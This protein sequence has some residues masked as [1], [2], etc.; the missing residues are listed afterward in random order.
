VR[1]PRRG[2]VIGRQVDCDLFLKDDEKVASRR[3]CGVFWNDETNRHELLDFGA[4]N[5]TR[6][7]GRRV[8]GA[9]LLA[10]GDQIRVA[11]Y[12]LV[13]EACPADI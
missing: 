10:A 13:F 7:N 3:H 11:E 12:V 2:V 1:R 4:R 6:L 9:T 8:R 5:G